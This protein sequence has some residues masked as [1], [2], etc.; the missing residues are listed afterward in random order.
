LVPDIVESSP[1][2]EHSLVYGKFKHRT[3][4]IT[5]TFL[6]LSKRKSYSTFSSSVSDLYV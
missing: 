4:S 5:P 6:F 2:S 3:K 1:L